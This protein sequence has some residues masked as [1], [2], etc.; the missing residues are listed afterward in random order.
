MKEHGLELYLFTPFVR[1]CG[2]HF[3]T[4]FQKCN[5]LVKKSE[6]TKIKYKINTYKPYFITKLRQ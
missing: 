1:K 2:I 6:K 4:F 5:I 3:N